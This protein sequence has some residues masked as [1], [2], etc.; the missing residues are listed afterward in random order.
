MGVRVKTRAKFLGL[1]LAAGLSIASG[2]PRTSPTCIVKD[3]SGVIGKWHYVGKEGSSEPS[4]PSES[5]RPASIEFRAD[6]T[7]TALYDP[8]LP[9][10]VSAAAFNGTW[11]GG[12]H[13]AGSLFFSGTEV[14]TDPRIPRTMGIEIALDHLVLVGAAQGFANTRYERDD[15]GAV[16]VPAA[17]GAAVAGEAPP[18]GEAAPAVEAAPAGA[19]VEAAPAGAAVE[20][21]VARVP[22]HT[23]TRNVDEATP[24]P[25]PPTPNRWHGRKI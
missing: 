14:L 16:A 23:P 21:T 8:P 4:T 19:A 13:C 22:T 24:T 10:G 6:H 2:C 1:S 18:A 15:G 12:Q 25:G 5:A 11:S 3:V 20:A 7:F 17:A 9:S